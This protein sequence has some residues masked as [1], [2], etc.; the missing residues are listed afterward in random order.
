MFKVRLWAFELRDLGGL[1]P[2]TR[3]AANDGRRLHL[4]AIETVRQQN[5]Y[6]RYTEV[7]RAG[8]ML[9]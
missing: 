2:E 3:K 5:G 4:P 1:G 9:D 7:G 8:V 6:R